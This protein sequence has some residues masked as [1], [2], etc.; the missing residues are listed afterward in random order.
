M[1]Y[2]ISVAIKAILA[3]DGA[4]YER[5]DVWIFGHVHS[6]LDEQYGRTCVLSNP[7]EGK[8]F[9]LRLIIEV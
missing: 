2:H 8:G 6:P 7:V 5:S 4:G 3:R 1:I 9:N